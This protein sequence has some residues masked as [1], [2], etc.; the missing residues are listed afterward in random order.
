MDLDR[1]KSWPYLILSSAII[2]I[3][4]LGSWWLYLVFTLAK[5]LKETDSDLLQG[6]LVLMVQWEGV[7]FLASTI[8]VGIA[9]LY[10]FYQDN[11]KTRATQAFYASLTHEL[12][13][14]LASMK[15]QSQVLNE[16]L[17]RES[18]NHNDIIKVRKYGKRI[19]QDSSRL[20][21][22]IDKHLQLARIETQKDF[23]LES[24]SINAVLKSIFHKY[25]NLEV[26][27]DNIDYSIKADNA[28]IMM[29]F[30]NLIENTIRHNSEAKKVE[31]TTELININSKNFIKVS[32]RDFGTPFKGDYNSLG[33]LFYKF[34]SPKG[35]GIGI[36]L[37]KKLM[38]L[39]SG[40][41]EVLNGSHLIFN[42]YF[43]SGDDE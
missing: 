35:S 42:L 18:L 25:S 2:F 37:I 39:Q 7:T 11:K 40:K 23:K 31:V 34:N 30:K 9:I 41:F 19:E 22:E 28:A 10:I 14:P 6:N 13:T 43:Q 1:T 15:L 20:E 5:K 38:K 12:K 26:E 27:L 33:K 24:L 29:I 32:Y 3:L 4:L 21:D 8:I 16:L 36:Y 17:D